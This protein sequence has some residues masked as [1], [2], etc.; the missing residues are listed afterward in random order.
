LGI[1]FAFIIA[2]FYPSIPNAQAC[3][4][5]ATAGWLLIFFTT[6]AVLVPFGMILQLGSRLILVA[7]Y[8]GNVEELPEWMK[9]IFAL[10][11]TA[12]DLTRGLVEKVGCTLLCGCATSS[13]ASQK[14]LRQLYVDSIL[15]HH[16]PE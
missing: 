7:F 4:C 1:W 12:V 5:C 16:S 3:L 15:Q 11:K 9:F 14:G 10:A 13:H 6:V 8:N 2:V